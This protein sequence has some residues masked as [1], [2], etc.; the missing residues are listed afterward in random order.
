MNVTKRQ[1]F[2]FIGFILSTALFVGLV[3]ASVSNIFGVL[4][5]IAIFLAFIWAFGYSTHLMSGD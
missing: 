5:A 4:V 1:V 3:T 2:G